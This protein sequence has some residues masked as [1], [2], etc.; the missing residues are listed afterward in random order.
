MNYIKKFGI[1]DDNKFCSAFLYTEEDSGNALLSEV[2]HQPSTA[3]TFIPGIDDL[4]NIQVESCYNIIESNR[5]EYFNSCLTDMFNKRVNINTPGDSD[6][7]YITLYVPLYEKRYWEVAKEILSFVSST[8]LKINIDLFLLSNDLEFLFNSNLAELIEKTSTHR[9]E[10]EYVIKEILN[11]KKHSQSISHL[12]LL[13]NSNVKG[14]SLNLNKDSLIRIIGEFSL[15]L[16]NHYHEIFNPSAEDPDKPITSLGISVLNFDKY[17]FVQYLLHKAYIYILDREGI[18]QDEVDVNK[19]SSTVQ[20][21]L[22]DNVNL[23]T[24]FYTKYIKPLLDHGQTDEEIISQI[25]PHLKD[26][27]KRLSSEF[28]SFIND[29]TLS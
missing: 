26:E 3:D 1:E 12:I 4:Y 7:L 8:T 2:K 18:M 10:S 20:T 17:N 14:I 25:L 11:Y 13:Q 5:Q 21:I 24:S 19:V 16:V 6:V 28:Q 29:P 23:Y 15:L 9:D 27:I 22:K